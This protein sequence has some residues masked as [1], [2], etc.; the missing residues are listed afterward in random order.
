MMRARN[1]AKAR[2]EARRAERDARRDEREVRIARLIESEEETGAE[3]ERTRE[4]LRDAELAAERARRERARTER[5]KHAALARC[6]SALAVSV[7]DLACLQSSL[8]EKETRCRELEVAN[9]TA[10][11][12][13][14][15]T[16]DEHAVSLRRESA[17]KD[18]VQ[19]ALEVSRAE[20]AA[21]IE[22]GARATLEART[23]AERVAEEARLERERET[24]DETN[25][26][27]SRLETTRAELR[28]ECAANEDFVD[29][30][31]RLEARALDLTRRLRAAEAS[32]DEHASLAEGF[33][34][35]ASD[36]DR[37]RNVCDDLR[38][39]LADTNRH[40]DALADELERA[41]VAA[42]LANADA[43]RRE[44]TSESRTRELE[45]A[46]EAKR[47][48]VEASEQ[49]ARASRRDELRSQ[50]RVKALETA[51]EACERCKADHEARRCGA[52]DAECAALSRLDDSE[53]ARKSA[54][55]ER[56]AAAK[57]LV[58]VERKLADAT[59]TLSARGDE[60]DALNRALSESRRDSAA[61][62]A[63]VERS[64]RAAKIALENRAAS[65]RAL[66]SERD[67]ASCLRRAHSNLAVRHE[68]TL[69]DVE[70]LRVKFSG[71]ERSRAEAETARVAAEEAAAELENRVENLAGVRQSLTGT[72]AV[73]AEKLRGA[74]AQC[75]ALEAEVVQ[76]RAGEA[77]AHETLRRVRESLDAETNKTAGLERRLSE[78][79]SN[80]RRLD[81]R[82]E[83]L[84]E[85][86]N[87]LG[88][89]CARLT[90]D[91]ETLETE[92]NRLRSELATVRDGADK[93]ASRGK[94]R[95]RYAEDLRRKLTAAEAALETLRA[96]VGARLVPMGSR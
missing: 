10:A 26:L 48:D 87:H 64:E 67:A 63:A 47:R 72:L 79:R 73:E 86:A 56:D 3:L 41:R 90:T 24:L 7:G 75:D 20:T 66:A 35:R 38:S 22:S 57:R 78:S 19:S 68:S 45:S 31:R 59:R 6:A 27:A 52:V 93:E 62:D 80:E 60:V 2:T 16:R 36:R 84:S 51:L 53:R 50:E 32:A 89:E 88:N 42:A 14:R 54:A 71:A 61:K 23:R 76:A 28:R 69:A 92:T 82:C 43:T 40:R 81:E 49:N 30:V 1:E 25:R 65:V 55:A 58:T 11:R 83:R 37:I 33:E 12:V 13:L 91:G 74:L 85:L 17:Q 4:R 29:V 5:D 39:T 44:A 15:E 8:A 94:L 34:G 21:A 95:E 96:G 9:A 18:A 77:R 46:L 70:R